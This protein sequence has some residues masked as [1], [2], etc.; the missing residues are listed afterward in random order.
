MTTTVT[1]LGE[2]A[3]TA[4]NAST[5]AI[6][7]TGYDCPMIVPDPILD[8]VVATTTPLVGASVDWFSMVFPYLSLIGSYL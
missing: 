3:L 6:L 8:E 1:V 5:T 2:V 7:C 4:E